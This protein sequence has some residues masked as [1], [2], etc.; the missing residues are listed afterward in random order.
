M[1]NLRRAAELILAAENICVACHENP[2]GDAIG[3]MVALGEGLTQLSKV[4]YLFSPDGVP[5][6]LSFLTEKVE[7][8]SS[9]PPP[10]VALLIIVD[11]ES[12]QRLGKVKELAGERTLIIDHHPSSHRGSS[13]TRLVDRRASATAEIV[14]K[15]LKILP[16]EFTPQIVEALLSAIISDTGGLRFSNTTSKTLNIVAKLM[17]AGGNLEEAYR[18]LYEERSEGY[19]KVLGEV[20]LRARVH[21]EGKVLTSFV[22]AEDHKKYSVDDKDLE[23]IIDYLRLLKGWQVILLLRETGN[24]VKVSIRSRYLDAGRFAKVFGGG[25]HKEAAGCT[26]SQPLEEAQRTLME[27]LGKWMEC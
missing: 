11:A 17:R 20:L 4:V 6:H 14:Y 10:K 16:V 24:G 26:I 7:I 21:F 1:R 9:P 15:L 12:Q 23:G 13:E 25:G 3:S 19:L 5:A 2:D 8:T 18:R 22:L 27:E